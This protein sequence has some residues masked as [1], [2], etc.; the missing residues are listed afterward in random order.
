LSGSALLA[1]LEESEPAEGAQRL[2]RDKREGFRSR[3]VILIIEDIM[4]NGVSGRGPDCADHTG[5][6]VGHQNLTAEGPEACRRY[7]WSFNLFAH[8]R[9]DL[10]DSSSPVNPKDAAV[11]ARY[12]HVVSKYVR[13]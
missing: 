12:D 9:R 8:G 11:L 13:W 2:V 1:R 10:R 5:R 3:L 4:S 7:N 6:L